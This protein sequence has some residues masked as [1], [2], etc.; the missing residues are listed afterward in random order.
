MNTLTENLVS[1]E[2]AKL[3]KE[4]GFYERSGTWYDKNDGRVNAFFPNCE[5]DCKA[6]IE[7]RIIFIHSQSLLQRWLREVHKLHVEILLT[8]NAPYKQYY[9]RIMEIGKYFSLS[10]DGVYKDTYEETLEIGLYK[11]LEL[12]KI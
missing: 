11:A 8:D 10:H 5:Y 1:F 4:K 2:T 12:I 3:A 6:L 7:N 9:Y